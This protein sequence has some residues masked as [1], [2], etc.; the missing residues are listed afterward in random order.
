M[1]FRGQSR[2]HRLQT[3]LFVDFLID[4]VGAPLSVASIADCRIPLMTMRALPPYFLVGIRRQISR[5]Q[6]A[7]LCRM[8]L[9]GEQ[10]IDGQQTVLMIYFLIGAI[11]TPL[12]VVSVADCRVPFMSPQT[13]PPDFFIGARC[14]I[15]GRQLSVPGRMPLSGQDRICLLKIGFLFNN[16]FSH[17]NSLIF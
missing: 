17:N 10:G 7:V 4:T 11:G 15:A 12:P 6:I 14:D 13:L 3:V 5:G 9:H 8:P 16:L 1:P 2:I